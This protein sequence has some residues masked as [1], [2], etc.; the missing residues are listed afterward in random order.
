MMVAYAY[1]Q[2]WWTYTI[3]F[4]IAECLLYYPVLQR[5]EC[6]NSQSSTGFKSS[7]T[8]LHR[9]FKYLKFT[10]DFNPYGLESTLSRMRTFA[11]R[12]FWNSGLDYMHQ[13]ACG[14]NRF[15]F[16]CLQNLSLIH[17]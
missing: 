7:Y 8:V 11:S 16:S 1:R 4:H 3:S 9:L 6:D 15:F 13:F 2:F 12:S 14:F 5:L 10:I 17:I